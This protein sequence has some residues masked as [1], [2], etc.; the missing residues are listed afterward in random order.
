MERAADSQLL[1]AG[2]LVDFVACEH[3]AAL[4]RKVALGLETRPRPSPEELLVAHKGQAHEIAYLARLRAE[5]KTVVDIAA[6]PSLE[7]R[8]SAAA[9]TIAALEAGAEIV[10]GATFLDEH[11]LGGGWS[12]VADFLIRIER[13]SRFGAWSYEVADT[14]LAR[15][16]KAATLIQLCVYGELLERVQGIAPDRMHAVLGD[17][18]TESFRCLDYTAYYRRVKERF[19]AFDP[20]AETYPTPVEHCARC[21]WSDA[22]I[23]RRRAD[24]YLSLVANV[25]GSQIVKLATSGIATV[26][27]LAVAGDDLRPARLSQP[28]FERIRAQAALQVAARTDGERHY[29]LLELDEKRGF[30][31][32]PQPDAGDLYFDMEGDP[33][34]EDGLEYLFGVSSFEDGERAFRPFWGH[35]RAG[36]REAFEGFIDFVMERRVRFPNLHVYHYAPYESVALKRLA[37]TH[38]TREEQVD[39]LLRERVLVDLY[40]VVRQALRASYESYS[41]KKIEQF[42][43]GPR[44]EDVKDAL[45]SVVTYERYRE[46]GDQRALD[47]ISAYNKADC[48]STLDLHKWLLQLRGEACER[49]ATEIAWRARGEAEASQVK[50]EDPS[51]ELAI[52]LTAAVADPSAALPEQRS[53]WLAGQMLSYHKR[54]AKPAWWALHDRLEKTP[55]ELFDDPES[56]GPVVAVLGIEPEVAKKS[57]IHTLEFPAQEYKLRPGA[58]VHD[59]ATYDPSSGKIPGAGTVVDIDEDRGRLRLLRG[60]SLR[61]VALPQA[62]VPGRPI[63]DEKQR[64]AL[65][66]FGR[67]Y[68]RDGAHTEYR[69]LGDLLRGDLPRVRGRALGAPLDDGS[70]SAESLAE[71][72]LALDASY[73]FIQ[74][75]PGSGKTWRGAHVIVEVLLAGRRVGVSSTSHKAIHNLL[76]RVETVA[77]ERGLAFRGMKKS[78]ANSPETVFVS[79][80]GFIESSDDAKRCYE[81]TDLGLVAGTAWLLADA[82]FDRT[83]D[84]LVIDEAG[85]VSLADAIALGTSARNLILLGDPMQLAQV[86]QARHPPGT[87]ASVLEHLLGERTTVAPDRGVFLPVTYRMQDEICRFISELA[88]DG[89]L[90][91]DPSCSLQRLDPSGA[92]LRYLPVAHDG[93][94]QQSSEEAEAIAEAVRRMLEGTVTDCKGTTRRL[95]QGDVMVVTPYNA[96]VRRLRRTLDAHGLGEVRAGTVDK[97]QGQEAMVVFFSMASSNGDELPRGLEFLFDRNRLNV[98]VSRARALAVLV[99]SPALL[100]THCTRVEQLRM[101]NA[102]CRFV[103]DASAL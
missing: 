10:H 21:R 60:P 44:S 6:G 2:K 26:A 39:V 70:G 14:K 45:G 43:L 47:E 96:Q 95:E 65:A 103:E 55:E 97:F 84:V 101:V 79:K 15:T 98:A 64:A 102:L 59:P 36:E 86:S 5:G 51:D 57:L 35:D 1:S 74:G 46:T 72:A 67:A 58:T 37:S 13:P 81:D 31:L 32:L 69:A 83:L 27:A 9:E 49:F 77:A 91:G 75:P 87:G 62:L 4:D 89:R 25:R 29:E 24:D 94:V 71:L 80:H 93:N 28:T 92:G 52:E 42:Y 40:E 22:C 100:D 53:R 85:Q 82:N 18:R 3:L 16:A 61:D 41:L 88:F 33:F 19:L 12:G 90:H 76:H 7:A 34:Y 54:E 48:D 73:L 66:R 17:G 20:A 63:P 23:A 99:C 11:E 56:I 50:P 78:T 38:A 8:R 68:A 30:A